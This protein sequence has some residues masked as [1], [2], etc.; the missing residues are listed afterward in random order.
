MIPLKEKCNIIIAGAWNRR[1]FSPEW[2]GR[3]IFDGKPIDVEI[4]LMLGGPFKF[5]HDGLELYPDSDR[6]IIIPKNLEDSSL[7][8][9][10]KVSIKILD[11]LPHTPIAAL[12]LNFAFLEESLNDRLKI[13]SLLDDPLLA[14]NSLEII[15]TQIRRLLKFESKICNLSI[16]RKPESIII[17]FNFHF[18]G[19]EVI[20]TKGQVVNNFIPFKQKALE[21]C[22]IVYD[23]QLE[24]A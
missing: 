13:F 18:E 5:I 9:A 8:A 23:I 19:S 17:D 7:S 10:E 3:W 24:G 1:L 15:E 12:G 20:G 4:P 16:V 6:L 21:I 11:L 14:G 2:V 22:K